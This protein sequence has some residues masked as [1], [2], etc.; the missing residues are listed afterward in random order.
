[1]TLDRCLN[2]LRKMS[3]FYA[4]EHI[5]IIIFKIFSYKKITASTYT[6]YKKKIIT[7]RS[8]NIL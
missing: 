2:L 5:I 4:H 3:I 1:M 8:S 7:I 6:R